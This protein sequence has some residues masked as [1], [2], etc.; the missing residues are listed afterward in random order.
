M[1]VLI[2]NNKLARE[3]PGKQ[4][5]A[6]ASLRLQAAQQTA[7]AAYSSSTEPG[8]QKFSQSYNLYSLRIE[9]N[10]TN[11]LIVGPRG[12]LLGVPLLCPY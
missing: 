3:L 2:E 11:Y 4:L 12:T 5:R 7:G 10:S 8:S 9:Q 1:S 6:T